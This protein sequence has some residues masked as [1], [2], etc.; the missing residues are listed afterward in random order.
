M[1]FDVKLTDNSRV[2]LSQLDNA[3]GLALE[4]IALRGKTHA[5]EAAPVGTPKST[6]IKDYRGGSLRHSIE[7][8]VVDNT[9]YIGTNLKAE[10]KVKN[11]NGEE[12]KI[13]EPYPVYVELGTG[14]HYEGEGS[15]HSPWTFTDKN[16]VEH[17][18]RGMKPKHFL[19]NAMTKHKKEYMNVIKNKLKG[20]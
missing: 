17:H 7:S 12:V 18:I 16:G 9:V 13:G 20:K 4:E 8:K 5:T 14:I 1:E 6:G 11:E 15:R 10:R 2:V 19:R 3:I